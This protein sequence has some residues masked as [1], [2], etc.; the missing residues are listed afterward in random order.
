MK[1]RLSQTTKRRIAP[2]RNSVKRDIRETCRYYSKN[3]AKGWHKGENVV[4]EQECG[5]APAFFVKALYAMANTRI[6]CKD[7]LPLL[8]CGIFSISNPLIG[9]GLIGFAL[10][11][12]INKI[13]IRFVKGINRTN[14]EFMPKNP[15]H[16]DLSVRNINSL[17]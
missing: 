8:G 11:K 2:Y 3:A 1:I 15:L 16:T 14:S 7:V 12:L 9:T 17:K 5:L 10:G 13:F 6:R 4:N